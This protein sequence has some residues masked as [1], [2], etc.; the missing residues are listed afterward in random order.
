MCHWAFRRRGQASINSDKRRNKFHSDQKFIS[1]IFRDTWLN[2]PLLTAAILLIHEYNLWNSIRCLR[3]PRGKNDNDLMGQLALY[4]NQCVLILD[5]TS[6]E[7]DTMI[8]TILYYHRHPLSIM[9]LPLPWQLE[10]LFPKALSSITQIAFLHFY[11]H[12][13]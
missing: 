8:N 11:R 6:A 9:K 13:K 5:V 7:P 1:E 4:S 12:C 2:A 3:T 10:K